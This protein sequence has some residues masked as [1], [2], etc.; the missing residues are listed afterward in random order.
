MAV[1][2]LSSV[3]VRAGSVMTWNGLPT[4]V[5]CVLGR[6][7]TGAHETCAYA[8]GGIRLTSIDTYATRTRTWIR[9][10]DDGLVVTITV[11]RGS[12]LIPIPFPLGR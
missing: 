11:P 1:T 7:P 9:R 2:T 10:Y 6:G 5:R 8:I 12:E 3:L 4:T